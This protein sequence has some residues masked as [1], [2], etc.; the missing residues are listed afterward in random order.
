M[1]RRARWGWLTLA[2]LAAWPAAAGPLA[3]RLRERWQIGQAEARAAG[4]PDGV[5][6]LSALRYGDDPAET[7]DAYLPAQPQHA[8]VLFM[9][10][11]GAW[12]LGDK[13][14]PAVFLHKVQRWAPQGVIVL[15]VNYPLLPH[16]APRQQAQSL[17]RA[18][19]F[20]QHQAPRWGGD[21]A[22]LVLMGHSAGAHLIA[23]L[24][25]DASL[26]HQAGAQAWRG[27]VALDSAALDVP[28][29]M[30]R[31]HPRF[32]DDAFGAQPADWRALSPLHQQ[33]AATPPILLV[34]SS[35]RA[36]ACAQAH[37]YADAAHALGARA[38][39]LP[40]DLSHQEINAQLGLD[41]AYTR[42]VEAFLR[43]ISR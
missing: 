43:D 1:L 10:H 34:C 40:Q 5:R 24:N 14:A 29:I 16:A 27:A 38:Q 39:V 2:L 17:A 9:V 31:P 41:N 25:A 11:G 15:S 33:T 20:V 30:Q 28:A 6:M 18:L 21:P 8:P 13:G 32:Y 23:L 22:R 37:A 42:Q 19:A 7:L 35:R 4:L 36:D 3:E 12:R 26:A